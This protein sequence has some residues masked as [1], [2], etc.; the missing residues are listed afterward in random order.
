LMRAGSRASLPSFWSAKT[1]N[2]QRLSDAVVMLTEGTT[3]HCVG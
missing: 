3:A 2:E 1:S